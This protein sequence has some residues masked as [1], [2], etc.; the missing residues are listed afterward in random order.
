MDMKPYVITC[1]LSAQVKLRLLYPDGEKQH[2]PSGAAVSKGNAS[3]ATQ[4]HQYSCNIHV[5]R[6]VVVVYLTI[7]K[8]PGHAVC[9]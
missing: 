5:D 1:Q 9:E 6:Q 3:T 2:E 7:C 4:D 8:Y